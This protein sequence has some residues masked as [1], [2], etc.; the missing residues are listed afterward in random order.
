MRAREM[1]YLRD[2]L[3]YLEPALLPELAT[4]ET[5]IFAGTVLVSM[6]TFACES[7]HLNFAQYTLHQF[8]MSPPSPLIVMYWLCCMGKAKGQ[9]VCLLGLSDSGKTL[10]YLRV[11]LTVL[12][13]MRVLL[14]VCM[15]TQIISGN[16][17]RT[18]NSIKENESQYERSDKVYTVVDFASCGILICCCDNRKESLLR[19]S[20]CQE[21]KE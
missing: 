8:N 4:Y 20:M 15:F 6:L 7:T 16:F 19:W 10:L 21:M 18:Q 12:Q 14:N 11:K 5:E 1:G 17:M 3:L 13:C 2:L 9:S